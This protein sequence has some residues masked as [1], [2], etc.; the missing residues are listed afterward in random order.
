MDLSGQ[1][2]AGQ[3]PCLVG[4]G[5]ARLPLVDGAVGFG[6]EADRIVEG[7]LGDRFALDGGLDPPGVDR[8]RGGRVARLAGAGRRTGAVPAVLV[9]VAVGDG[10]T[11]GLGPQHHGVFGIG[12]DEL[13]QRCVMVAAIDPAGL[14]LSRTHG[15]WA[16]EVGHQLLSQVARGLSG[17]RRPE[18]RRGRAAQEVV[19]QVVHR[20]LVDE[21][22]L[23]GRRPADG[24]EV[25]ERLAQRAQLELH[26]LRIPQAHVRDELVQGLLPSL[27]PRGQVR[28]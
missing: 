19:E 24:F 21:R 16:H 12:G 1:R 25:V 14:E 5:Q 7:R 6:E 3:L 28:V 17:G 8:A 4:R 13:L 27:H 9:V 20:A 15:L 11:L 2:V 18:V 22:R 10:A 23:V 26:V